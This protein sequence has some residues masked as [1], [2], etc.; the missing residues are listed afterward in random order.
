MRD[1]R[2]FAML[3]LSSRMSSWFLASASG[4]RPSW[5]ALISVIS[6]LRNSDARAVMPRMHRGA[7]VCAWHSCL[8]TGDQDKDY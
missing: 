8:F 1:M 4:V 2:A 3:P 6:S 5:L 7:C